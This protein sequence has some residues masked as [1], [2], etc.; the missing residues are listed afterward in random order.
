MPILKGLFVVDFE[1]SNLEPQI[2]GQKCF[3]KKTSAMEFPFR[4]VSNLGLNVTI[5][6]LHHMRILQD[7]SEQLFYI[8]E[9]L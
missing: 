5:K 1:H 7:F 6:G 2:V 4:K 8:M 9:Q 3:V